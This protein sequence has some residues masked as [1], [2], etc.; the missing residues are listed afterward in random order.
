MRLVQDPERGRKRVGAGRPSKFVIFHFI[1]N[2]SFFMSKTCRPIL[3]VAVSLTGGRSISGGAAP[4]DESDKHR[5]FRGRW[6]GR[7]QE[8]S[9]DGGGTGEF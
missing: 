5:D 1:R 9:A 3:Q 7:A 4:D 8:E 2:S 6:H